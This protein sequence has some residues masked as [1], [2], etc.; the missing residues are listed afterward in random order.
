MSNKL[1]KS[2]TIYCPHSYSEH[3]HELKTTTDGEPANGDGLG[4][5]RIYWI[6]IPSSFLIL[7]T[8][9]IKE[10]TCAWW[11]VVTLFLL[12]SPK[13][14]SQE[15][16]YQQPIRGGNMVLIKHLHIKKD[17]ILTCHLHC[18]FPR[19]KNIYSIQIFFILIFPRQN[20]FSHTVK[21]IRSVSI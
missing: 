21:I 5:S 12:A 6:L 4:A 11:I 14:C 3:L 15:Q 7:T 17:L 1:N 8:T 10:Q 20:N 16:E 13:E 9:A 2:R 19:A 18:I